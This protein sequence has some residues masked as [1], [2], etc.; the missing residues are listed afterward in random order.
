VTN[1]N[2]SGV[3]RM[4]NDPT[5]EGSPRW[6]PD[7]QTLLF[8]SNRTGAVRAVHDERRRRKLVSPADG[9]NGEASL[10]GTLIGDPAV[11]GDSNGLI[12]VFYRGLDSGLWHRWQTKPDGS[13]SSDQGALGGTLISSATRLP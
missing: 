5:A 3:R 12:D 6:S 13:W 2:G 7:S 10:G 9:W 8:T 4:T 1:A 11:A